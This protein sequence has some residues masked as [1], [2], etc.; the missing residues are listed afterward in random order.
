MKKYRLTNIVLVGLGFILSPLTWWN[1]L[2]VN[3]PLAYLFS[4][5]FSLL[6]EKLFM[7]SFIL[8][9]WLTN[10][11]GFL[12][13][14]WGGKGLIQNKKTTIP[15]KQGLLISV[16]YTILIVVLVQVGWISAPTYYLGKF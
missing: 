3:V 6:H 8:G 14:H 13:M 4:L 2:V 7:P 16:I 15:I 9:Y 11:L 1:D 12:L 10:L 5:P